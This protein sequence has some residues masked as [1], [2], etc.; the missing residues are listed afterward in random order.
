MSK[1]VLGYWSKLGQ[2][3][4]KY[5]RSIQSVYFFFLVQNIRLAEKLVFITFFDN[6]NFGN[7]V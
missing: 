4:P 1:I 5:S 3:S 6:F 2:E 7:I